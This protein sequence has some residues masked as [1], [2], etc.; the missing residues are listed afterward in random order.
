MK[1]NQ[2]CDMS[3]WDCSASSI[4]AFTCWYASA[5]RAVICC[6]RTFIIDNWDTSSSR[7]LH[8]IIIIII[9]IIIIIIISITWWVGLRKL[10]KSVALSGIHI[11]LDDISFLGSPTLV[12]CLKVYYWVFAFFFFYRT[13]A[14]S[15]RGKASHQMY[16]RG[17]VIG[18]ATTIDP[19]ISSTP[20]LIF[21]GGEGETVRFLALSLNNARL[22]AAVVWSKIS[23][24]CLNS[25]CS[26]IW[27]CSHQ[28]WCRSVHAF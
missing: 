9:S 26:Y 20:H 11:S 1:H 28:I 22:W 4:Q 24:P 12:E 21:T 14:L 2:T 19:D 16:T 27:Q 7:S 8:V 17:S 3:N 23:S 13:T 25:V 15:T 18:A 5:S 10:A 6:T